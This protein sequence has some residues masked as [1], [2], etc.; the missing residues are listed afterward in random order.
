MKSTM[1]QRARMIADAIAECDTDYRGDLLT[2]V[3]QELRRR[4]TQFFTAKC[5]D[6]ASL[7]YGTS[8]ERLEDLIGRTH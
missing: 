3:S 6:A 8:G 4:H 1:G 2:L 5:I 7:V